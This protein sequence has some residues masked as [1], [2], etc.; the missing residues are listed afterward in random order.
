MTTSNILFII[1]T[2]LLTPHIAYGGYYILAK[3]KKFDAVVYGLGLLAGVA[4][5]FMLANIFN[6]VYWFAG[7]VITFIFAILFHLRIISLLSEIS[8][9]EYCNYK[10][11]IE[12]YGIFLSLIG[13]II[14][15][16]LPWTAPVLGG[17]TIIVILRLS[18]LVLFIKKAYGINYQNPAPLT[19]PPVSIVIIAFNE[20]KYIGELLESIKKQTYRN[21]EVILVDDHSE[22]DTVKIAHSYIH[23][24]PLKIVQKPVRGCSRSRNFGAKNSTGEIILFLDADVI[25]PPDFLEKGLHEFSTRHLSS[26]YFDFEPIADKKID[27]FF[28][29]VYRFWLKAVQYH[30]P[31]AVGSCIMVR[32]NLHEKILFDETVVMAEDF[33]YI[34]R[35]SHLGKFRMINHPRYHLSWRRFAVE[36]RLKLV[37]KYLLFELHRQLIGEIRKPIMTYKFGHYDKKEA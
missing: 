35:G 9:Q 25:L 2:L 32:S 34:R 22:D 8:L 15:T 18:W 1:S 30:N 10:I 13:I 20:E 26:A 28:T 14:V 23:H 21:F 17:L 11:F 7:I 3:M 27:D 33:D 4:Q 36:H 6:P 12:A 24:F 19:N 31:R 29:V 37:I 16:F 5:I